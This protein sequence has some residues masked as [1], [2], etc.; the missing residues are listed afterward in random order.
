MKLH[1]KGFTLM[2]LLIVVLIIGLLTSIALPMYKKAVE[3]SRASDALTTL[4][5]VA[6]SE[7]DWYLVKNNYT[8]D[9]SDLDIE[10]TGEIEDDVLETTYYDYELLDKGILAT[11]TNGE[12]SLYK[13]YEISQIMCSPSEHYIC[14]NF[15]KLTKEPCQKIGMA[16]ANSNSTCYATNEDR[17]KDLYGD[18]MWN[19]DGN[20]SYCGYYKT[21]YQELGDGVI[22][23]SGPDAN[24]GCGGS[25]IG[26]GGTCIANG[27]FGCEGSIVNSGVC[28]GTS[29]DGCGFSTFNNGGI[30]KG[31]APPVGSVPACFRAIL[32]S[33]SVCEGN[34]NSTCRET[35]I[36]EGS[37]CLANSRSCLASTINSGGICRGVSTDSS[38]GFYYSACSG[39]QINAGGKCEGSGIL[40]CSNSSINEGGIC[41]GK[42]EG[43]CAASAVKN[44]GVCIGTVEKSCTALSVQEGGKCIANAPNTCTNYDKYGIGYYG[45]GCCEGQYCPGNAPKCACPI[46]E[47]TG[48]HLTSC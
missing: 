31:N 39:A 4:Q 37:I 9:F 27:T 28:I 29:D 34:A 43:A 25:K 13:D 30:C 45:T 6:K 42:E 18:S 14:D 40:A 17:C 26:D 19:E 15:D 5:A 41:E 35:T 46:D 7:H 11:R 24:Y 48:K 3:K 1:K 23:D 47:N 36:N 16:W 8:K 21:K 44:G 22:C 2:E 33:G 32:N 20:N 38:G 12:Y 10:L